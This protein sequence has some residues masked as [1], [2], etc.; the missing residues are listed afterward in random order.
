MTGPERADTKQMQAA[1]DAIEAACQGL[2][3]NTG[4]IVELLGRLAGTLNEASTSQALRR[5][6]E[7]L[8]ESDT[9]IHQRMLDVGRYLGESATVIEAVL[10]E[11]Q[12]DRDETTRKISGDRY[13]SALN[14]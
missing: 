11:S 3:D 10:N 1:S 12:A 4:Q 7:Q 13:G 2:Q 8:Q 5:L 6:G 9:A 14:G